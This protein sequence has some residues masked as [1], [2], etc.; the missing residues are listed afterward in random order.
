M[1]EIRNC[2]ISGI[3]LD[4]NNFRFDRPNLIGQKLYGKMGF[5]KSW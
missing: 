2:D 1:M 5:D 3:S 4:I